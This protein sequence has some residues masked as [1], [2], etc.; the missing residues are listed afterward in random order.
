MDSMVQTTS[1]G[2]EPP[3]KPLRTWWSPDL[4]QKPQARCHGWEPKSSSSWGGRSD[5]ERLPVTLRGDTEPAGDC[6]DPEAARFAAR[7]RKL[8]PKIG[9]ITR[10][11]RRFIAR[12]ILMWGDP[13]G[14]DGLDRMERPCGWPYSIYS[15][16][17]WWKWYGW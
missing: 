2:V 12:S 16:I 5:A 11:T 7:S 14:S 4:V 15:I 8:V 9:C 1:Q 10:A 6:V 17:G 13:C 3:K